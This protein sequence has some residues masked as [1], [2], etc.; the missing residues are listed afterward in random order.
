ME[1][2]VDCSLVNSYLE[3]I[4][5][6]IRCLNSLQRLEIGD[7][8][9][10]RTIPPE[11]GGLKNMRRLEIRNC[12]R[13]RTLPSE[14]LCLPQLQQLFLVRFPQE[15]LRIADF[16]VNGCSIQDSLEIL[17]LKWNS[18]VDCDD[19]SKVCHFVS[20]CSR[21]KRLG[22]H[23]NGIASFKPFIS[24]STREALPSRLQILDLFDNP[25]LYCP[26]EEELE[27]LRTFLD[28]HF[29]LHDIGM[30]HPR[31]RDAKVD[32][33]LDLNRCGRSLLLEGETPTLP[34]SVW[35]IV[36]QRIDSILTVDE[37]DDAAGDDDSDEDDSDDD[38]DDSDVPTSEGDEGDYDDDSDGS[39]KLTETSKE[40]VGRVASVV[41]YF[42][43]NGPPFA[44]R[45]E[46]ERYV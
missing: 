1:S 25:F 13:L 18:L 12:A 24:T 26:V 32:Y 37:E 34:L 2:L 43:R 3:F 31:H 36:L 14:I 28:T 4:P 20:G 23:F 6:E 21:L 19:L 39:E 7:C 8:S 42:L 27:V 22:L 33:L 15:E 30:A 44:A 11:I 5:S 17:D 46:L 10:L 35:P 41:Y 45:G 29:H 16:L 9:R 38:D 40:H